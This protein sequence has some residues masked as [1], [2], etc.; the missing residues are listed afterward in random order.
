MV[1]PETGDRPVRPV[2]VGL[3]QS[4]RP[5]DGPSPH[6][7]AERLV[8]RQLYASLIRVDCAGEL[9][10][11][12]ADRWSSDS[13]GRRWTL[14]LRPGLRFSDGSPIDAAAVRA[15][16]ERGWRDPR[17]AGVGRLDARPVDA[18]TLEVERV[19]PELTLPAA[20]ADP[21]LAVAGPPGP[22]GRP[23]T[24]GAFHLTAADSAADLP[25]I[26]LGLA[27]PP[28]T[29]PNGGLLRFVRLRPDTDLRDAL[30]RGTVDVLVTRDPTVLDYARA[31]PALRVAP[32]PWDRVY[33]LLAP[34]SGAMPPPEVREGLAR[35]AVRAEARGAAPPYWWHTDSRCAAAADP[36]VPPA[37]SVVPSLAY[38]RDDPLARDLADRLVALA[39]SPD[40]PPWLSRQLTE[41]GAS[42]R[43]RAV[44]VDP[45]AVA[46]ALA[47]ASAAAA[48]VPLPRYRPASCA[49]FAH[50][51]RGL[52]PI[53]LIESRP[54][55]I[56]RAGVPAFTVDGDGALRFATGREP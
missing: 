22:D 2:T 36:V 12:L 41:G 17:W 3:D 30:D 21:A 46:A 31:Q 45:S 44:G 18:L 51:L 11:A 16:W 50:L 49:E 8:Y 13:T 47:G 33:A 15:S 38:P 19:T 37:A 40:P 20:L 28:G 35:D 1:V 48:V 5:N 34:A 43:V 53:P 14:F 24:S 4:V 54:H 10:P 29:L 25:W 55:V 27:A 39:A 52:V 6:H 7:A 26:E 23:A 56:A 32:L 9:R 42:A